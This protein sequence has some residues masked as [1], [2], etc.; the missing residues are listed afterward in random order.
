MFNKKQAQT[1]FYVVATNDHGDFVIMDGPFDT[2]KEAYDRIPYIFFPE[3]NRLLN[4]SPLEIVRYENLAMS[5]SDD[6]ED[7]P[8]F[9]SEKV[10]QIRGNESTVIIGVSDYLSLSEENQETLKKKKAFNQIAFSFYFMALKAE[11]AIK[12]DEEMKNFNE[13][14]NTFKEEFKQIEGE[15]NVKN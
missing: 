12:T 14:L 5:D 15:K 8:L 4:K 11:S 3:A 1:K 10:S 7:N 6:D 2:E 13:A 9:I